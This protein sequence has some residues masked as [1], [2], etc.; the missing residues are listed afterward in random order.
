M[1]LFAQFGLPEAALWVL[2]VIAGIGGAFVGWFITDPLARI[3]HRLVRAK[4][5]PGWTLPWIKMA[6]AI[7]FGLL[8]YFLVGLGGGPGGLGY[9]PGLGGGPGKG[10]GQGGTQA[11]GNAAGARTDNTPAVADQKPAEKTPVRV[12]RKRIEIEVL[13]GERYKGDGRY[14]LLRGTGNAMTVKEIDAYFQEHAGKLEVQIVLTEDSPDD[15]FTGVTRALRQAADR[16]QITT[17]LNE[18]R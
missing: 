9:G 8:V 2:R 18:K 12:E 13:G 1:S 14:Y 10:P 7:A 16:H 17:T 6:G 5:I 4:P 15:A 3:T 11:H